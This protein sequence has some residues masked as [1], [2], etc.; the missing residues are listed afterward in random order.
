LAAKLK[1]A[2]RREVHAVFHAAAV[3]DFAFGKVWKRAQTGKLV[4][5]RG[6]KL[7][8]R[9]DPLLAEL[10]STPK[11]ISD[12]RSWYPTAFLAGWKYE[13]DGDRSAAVAAGQRQFRESSVDVCVLNGPAYGKGFGILR[14]DG[15]LT[16]Y[17]G[18]AQ[19]FRALE[20]CCATGSGLRRSAG[21]SS[22]RPRRRKPM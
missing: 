12:L 7:P 14:P 18:E 19:L 1:A 5:V 4:A 3:S 17:H 2:A 13:V 20:S 11:I 16:H 8:T 15:S 21:Q 6:G 22:T 9:G 10:V